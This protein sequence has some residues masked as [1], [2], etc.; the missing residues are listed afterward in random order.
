MRPDTTD[1]YTRLVSRELREEEKKPPFP[2]PKE[3]LDMTIIDK[4]NL[5]TA[6]QK[7]LLLKAVS[8]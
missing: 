7:E 8:Y 6:E 2:E 5:I 4:D 3:I 1:I